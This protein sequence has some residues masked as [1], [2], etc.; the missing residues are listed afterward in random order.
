[1][2]LRRRW[3][4]VVIAVVAVGCSVLP[5]PGS[6]RAAAVSSATPEATAIGVDVLRRGGNA[7]DAAVAISLALG[8]SEPA[9]SG[10]G[11]QVFILRHAP[12]EPAVVING[13]TRAPGVIP[14]EVTGADLVGRRAATVPSAVAVLDLAHRR[15]GSGKFSWS[16][17]VLP[18][19]KLAEHGVTMGPFRQAAV[20]RYAPAGFGD[21]GP[22]LAATLRQIASGGAEVFYRGDL[23]RGIAADMAANGGWMTY[24]DLANFPAPVIQPALEGSYRGYRVH[25]LP[26]PAAGWVVLLALNMLEQAPLEELVTEAGQI[27][28]MATALR[29]AHTTRME[30]PVGD[31]TQNEGRLRR[32]TSKEEAAARHAERLAERHVGSGETTHFSVV[33]GDGVMVTVTQSLNNYFGAKVAHPKLGFLYNDYMREFVRGDASHAFAL[34]PSALPFSS[35]SAT[36]LSKDGKAVFG[37]GSPGG[38]RIVSAVVQVTSNWVDQDM[39]LEA[40]VAAPRIHVVPET[41]RLFVETAFAPPVL[42]PDLLLSLERR[43]FRVVVPHTSLD[44]RGLSPYFGGVHAVSVTVNGPRAAA[45]PRRDGVGTVIQLPATSSAAPCS[46]LKL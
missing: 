45:D 17:L 6:G 23:A 22:A 42:S 31:G 4:G 43:G 30:N 11:G 27:D 28:W 19:A 40:A 3:S 16:E 36:I 29:T 7:M 1:M 18:A 33:D 15:F 2:S 21:R 38:R 12:G 25:T 46:G 13:S 44:R 32:Y 35:M 20:L 24:E 26:P 39:G 14:G 34:A 37:V 5:S 41:Q 8:V 10:I 9:G